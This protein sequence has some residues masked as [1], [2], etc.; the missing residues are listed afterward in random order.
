MPLPPGTIPTHFLYPCAIFAHREEHEVTTILGS[1]VSVCL[2]DMA[3]GIGGIN[4]FMLPLWNGAGL[5]TPRFGNVAVDKLIDRMLSFGCRKEKLVAKVFGGAQVIV[6]EQ[7]RFG[8]GERNIVVAMEMLDHHGIPVIAQYLGGLQGM[9]I[10]FNTR[11]GSVLANRISG[12][13]PDRQGCG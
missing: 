9:K 12:G 2:V 10:R 1:C 4:H 13:G 7:S 6:T 3:L 11:T 8:I 5:P